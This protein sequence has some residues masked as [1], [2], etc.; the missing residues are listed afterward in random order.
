MVLVQVQITKK[1]EANLVE[2]S[3]GEYVLTITML[4]KK[5]YYLA[6]EL[7]VACVGALGQICHAPT[8]GDL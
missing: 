7:N 6:I 4:V 1:L 8:K 3:R 2:L 5:K